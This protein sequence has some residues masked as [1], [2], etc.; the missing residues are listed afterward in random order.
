M[1]TAE[2]VG[3]NRSDGTDHEY[4]CIHEPIAEH[5]VVLLKP[6]SMTSVNDDY[7]QIHSTFVVLA[8]INNVSL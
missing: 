1:P 7:E 8:N 4:S 2:K 3:P 6:T 5:L